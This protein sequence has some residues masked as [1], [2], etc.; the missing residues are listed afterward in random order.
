[1]EM[2]ANY[3][4]VGSFVLVVLIGIF[5]SILWLGN[6]Q[7]NRQ[8]DYYDIYFSGSV[9]GLGDGAAVDY[10]GVSIGRVVEIRLDPQNLDLVRV[11]I[12]VDSSVPIKS[13]TVASLEITGITGVAYVEISGGSHDASV[14]QRQEGQRYPVIASRPSQLQTVVASAPELLNRLIV[15]ADRLT[16]VLDDRNRAAISSILENL[17]EITA[18]ALPAARKLDTLVDSGG[19]ALNE[20]RTTMV[21]ANEALIELKRVLVAV[22]G[23]T[24][25]LAATIKELNLTATH[26]DAMVQEVRPGVRDLSQNGLSQL[27]QLIADARVLVAGLTRVVAELERDPARFLLGEHR[28]GYTPK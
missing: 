2:R 13:D 23:M 3:V 22:D 27:Q 18:G 9:T 11:T 6:A 14:L 17:Q 10:N 5:I 1:M 24:P 4:M 8:F 25:D 15:V 7:F 19:A 28:Q 20:A 12:E 16:N 21:T 26:A